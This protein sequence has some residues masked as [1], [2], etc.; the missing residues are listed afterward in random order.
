VYASTAN[1]FD[2]DPNVIESDLMAFV[3][4]IQQ[5]GLILVA[6]RG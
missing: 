2:A 3:T 4:Q 1:H 5:E 6:A